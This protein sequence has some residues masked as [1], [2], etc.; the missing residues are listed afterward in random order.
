MSDKGLETA[1][2]ITEFAKQ[3]FGEHSEQYTD[4]LYLS[5]KAVYLCNQPDEALRLVKMAIDISI[6]K[7]RS[8]PL[9]DV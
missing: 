6:A 9:Q 2:R 1:Q 4:G 7:P 3:E 8:G 5:S